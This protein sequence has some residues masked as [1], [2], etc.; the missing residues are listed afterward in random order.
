MDEGDS[1][2]VTEEVDNA[3]NGWNAIDSR[4]ASRYVDHVNETHR[5]LII[6]IG[7][8]KSLNGFMQ[9]R[10]EECLEDPDGSATLL[11]IWESYGWYN[12]TED[13]QDIKRQ[14][15][16]SPRRSF[17]F[18]TV[19]K[20]ILPDLAAGMIPSADQIEIPLAFLKQFLRDPVKALEGSGRHSAQ[21]GRSIHL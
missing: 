16:T 8:R 17:Y 19:R 3:E 12:Y 18:D 6:A 21:G 9:R 10:Y 1:Y 20:E 14:K 11:T 13:K 7:Q 5:G 15:E 4:I 2:P